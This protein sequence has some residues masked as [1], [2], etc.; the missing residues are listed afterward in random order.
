MRGHLRGSVS[1]LDGLF[2]ATVIDRYI[3]HDVDAAIVS[4]EGLPTEP[5]PAAKQEARSLSEDKPAAAG[6]SR[7]GPSAASAKNSHPHVGARVA[8]PFDQDQP[9][10]HEDLDVGLLHLPGGR[11]ARTAQAGNRV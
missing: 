10:L 11:Q 7:C 2:I 5:G 3:A 1:P 4:L 8:T 6:L 9:A